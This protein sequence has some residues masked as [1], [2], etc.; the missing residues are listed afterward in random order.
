MENFS[1]VEIRKKLL[2]KELSATEVV[3]H[4]LNQ[5]D[6]KDE[7]LNSYI[8]VLKEDSLEKA[9]NFDEN[10]NKESKK[11]MSGIPIAVKDVFSTKDILTT[12]ASHI[13]DGY[14]PVFESTVTKRLLDEGMIILGKTNLDQFCH[15]SSTVTSYYGPTRNPHDISKL[16]GG[17]SG[18]S[19]AAT[20]ADLC[21]GSLGT[22]TAGSI[23]LP[24]SWCGVVGLKPTYGRV[25]RYGVLA[26]GSSLD[27]PGPIVKS[28]EDAAY[29]LSIVAGYDKH[30]FTTYKKEAPNYFENLDPSQIKDMKFAIPKE[31]LEVKLSDGVRKNFEESVK[32]LRSLGAKIETV[33]LMDPKFAMAVYTVTCRSEVSSNLAR[34]DG[35]RYGLDGKE[36]DTIIDYFT[37]TRGEG[38]GEEPKRRVMTGTFSLSAGYADEYFK[39]S[40]QVRQLIRENFDDIFKKYDVIVAPSTPSTALSDEDANNPLFGEMADILAEGSSLAGLPGLTIPNGLEDNMPTGI[41]FISNHLEEQSILNVGLALEK[42]LE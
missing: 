22:E 16:P 30:D 20:A 14:K 24:A 26:M 41:Q 2:N 21:A 9:K 23:R 10:F 40:E 17:S 28:V 7:D 6:K 38:F 18:G 15:G 37:S 12:C 1:I 13:L 35:T 36:K 29:I 39:K 33:S 31:Y 42:E 32:L 8:T 4:Y 34:Y 11:K 25:S 5:I 3:Q 19:A 27:S